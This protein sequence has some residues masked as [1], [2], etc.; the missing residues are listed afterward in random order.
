MDKYKVLLLRRAF[1]GQQRLPA[2]RTPTTADT[3]AFLGPQT[4][5]RSGTPLCCVGVSPGLCKGLP[6]A[7]V[8][9]PLLGEG[10]TGSSCVRK[11][12]LG[13]WE[14]RL[15]PLYVQGFRVSFPFLPERLPSPPLALPT[16]GSL[17]RAPPGA[18][19]GSDPM[20]SSTE[21]CPRRRCDCLFLQ[22]APF[23]S[24]IV[25]LRCN[26][27][28]LV[29]GVTLWRWRCG[30][31]APGRG[32]CS[33]WTCRVVPPGRTPR[34]TGSGE[35]RWERGRPGPEGQGEGGTGAP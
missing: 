9:F 27:M 11:A 6:S 24:S 31:Q 8:L 14:P 7:R 30:G 32:G 1:K 23:L 17:S 2:Y 12:T 16:H 21:A 22:E 10:Y 18:P 34:D 15:S 35:P 26:V 4:C 33:P 28:A 3:P 20:S 25:R 5:P 29:L 19:V 13:A